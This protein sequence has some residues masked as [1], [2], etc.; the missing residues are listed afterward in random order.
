M[1]NIVTF[2]KKIQ[3]QIDEINTLI[4]KIKCIDVFNH[5]KIVKLKKRRVKSTL[6]IEGNTQIAPQKLEILHNL[7][8]L[9]DFKKMH[10]YIALNIILNKKLM[11]NDILYIR[12]LFSY[13]QS[14]KDCPLK[15][16][17]IFYYDSY[18]YSQYLHISDNNKISDRFLLTY[19]LYEWENIFAYIPI[20]IF[21]E[22]NKREVIHCYLL[23]NPFSIN[24]HSN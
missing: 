8:Y 4:K 6:L 7:Y 1:K 2:E 23:R 20:E 12:G 17:I 16:S 13:I 24:I 9:L 18:R 3:R 10:H 11:F 15:K 21:I 19:I 5:L 22:K 14:N